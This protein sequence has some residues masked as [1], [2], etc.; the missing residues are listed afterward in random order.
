LTGSLQGFVAD[1]KG[2][3]QPACSAIMKIANRGIARQEG[4]PPMAHAKR[5]FD[6]ATEGG[7]IV[8]TNEIACRHQGLLPA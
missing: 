8:M 5:I 7:E 6:R 4:N 2:Q 1:H 3:R